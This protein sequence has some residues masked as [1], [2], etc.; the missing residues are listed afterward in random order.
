MCVY[1]LDKNYKWYEENIKFEKETNTV[2][3]YNQLF[4]NKV[5][6]LTLPKL[7]I[8][9]YC[10]FEVGSFFYVYIEYMSKNNKF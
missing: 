1:L 9:M 6:V 4:L 8:P 2:F 10:F 3:L 7:K 5:L